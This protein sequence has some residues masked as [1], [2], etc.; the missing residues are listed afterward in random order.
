MVIWLA[1]Y[2]RSGNTLLRI[3]LKHI[4]GLTTWSLYNDPGDIG[5]DVA[6]SD[7]VGHMPLPD[8]F[9]IEKA[10]ADDALHIIKTHGYPLNDKD[11]AIYIVR[12][13]RES[14]LSYL[15]YENTYRNGQTTLWDVIYGNVPFGSWSRHLEMWDPAR[16]RNTL[17]LRFEDFVETPTNLIGEISDFI[18]VPP[19]GTVTPSFAE[20][21]KINPRFFVSG[22][23]DSWK[24]VFSDDEHCAFLLRHY[25]AMVRYG[26]VNELPDRFVKAQGTTLT[27]EL[28]REI[29]Y[30]QNTMLSSLRYDLLQKHSV[31]ET[32]TGRLSQQISRAE[33]L[34]Q[35]LQRT[36][37]IMDLNAKLK[38]QETHTQ[39]LNKMLSEERSQSERL[40]QQIV[41]KE[42]QINAVTAQFGQA[43]EQVAK[44]QQEHTMVRE[45]LK[46]SE[47]ELAVVQESAKHLLEELQIIKN[48]RRYRF[49]NM[50][51]RS[52]SRVK[53]TLP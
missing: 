6:T 18:G 23:K 45:R 32:L 38:E 27:R 19:T 39:R 50:I 5:A 14:T 49:G 12:D 29:E 2:P 24:T 48:S 7:V 47:K 17:L 44:E 33:E 37:V 31:I 16:R 35:T 34:G 40:R 10:R 1:S 22:K 28:S 11:H 42:A 43:R 8:D 20:L 9:D 30:L 51:A 41:E 21:N 52:Y 26:Y 46:T 15:K 3:V 53:R 25:S 13:G 36:S 4:F